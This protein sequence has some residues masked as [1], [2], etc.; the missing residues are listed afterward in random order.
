MPQGT[1][2]TSADR[3][4]TNSFSFKGGG[5]CSELGCESIPR[6]RGLGLLTAFFEGIPASLQESQ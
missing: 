1:W 6:E 4:I 3:G 5:Q 2:L